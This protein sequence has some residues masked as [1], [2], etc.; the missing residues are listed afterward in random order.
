MKWSGKFLIYVGISHVIYRGMGNILYIELCER[1]LVII[2]VITLLYYHVIKYSNHYSSYYF[3][4]L[5][6]L[7]L[8]HFII[9]LLS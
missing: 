6:L 9:T 5:S 1:I 3:T 2:L 8:F 4:L 7:S